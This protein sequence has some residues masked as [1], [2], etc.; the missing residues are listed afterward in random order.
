MKLLP[1]VS[2]LTGAETKALP[3]NVDELS[4]LG[5]ECLP[6]I[7]SSVNV[8]RLDVFPSPL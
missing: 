6:C 1:L 3:L 2:F 8:E 5:I 4:V 7:L